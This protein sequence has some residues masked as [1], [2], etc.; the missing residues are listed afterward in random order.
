MITSPRH[1]PTLW[2]VLLG[3]LLMLGTTNAADPAPVDLS[4][5][6]DAIR[7]RHQV[8]G[9]AAA[10]IHDGK[11]LAIGAC[12]QR[13]QGSP[14]AITLEDRFH[15]G[16]CTKSMTATLAALLIREGK[17]DLQWKT[18]IGEVFVD[19]LT[20]I[21]PS[22]HPVTLEQLLQHLGGC[23]HDV[24]PPIWNQ[25]RDPKQTT[26]QHR[27]NLVH[28]IL[29]H[30]PAQEPGALPHTY[31][32]A[33]YVIAGAMLEQRTG[34]SW[35]Q[36]ITDYLFTPLGLSSF[37]FGTPANPDQQT[38]DQ[39]W[40]HV[41]RDGNPHP[42]PPGPT[43]DN[44][45][46]IG[47]AGTVHGSIRDLA[48]YTNLHTQG[49]RTG[50]HIGTI[51]LTPDDFTR[52]H[53]PP[54]QSTYASGWLRL[55]RPWAGRYALHHNGTNTMNY[56]VMW[57]SPDHHFSMVATCNLGGPPGAKACDDAM[58]LLLKRYKHLSAAPP[59][60]SGNPHK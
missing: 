41:P 9:L 1:L 26:A 27:T 20:E 12:G 45:A 11:I 23:P 16:S 2:P 38:I 10:L 49:A 24:P 14:E 22:Y 56:A 57:L 59:I 32:N 34:R 3:S 6:L 21:H 52:L 58:A 55:K 5:Q 4:P 37:G 19:R 39:P 43:G 42:I 51:T 28:G 50:A 7:K 25:L 33:G 60:E 36:L 18:S 8:P 30:K 35:E 54:A 29:A 40:G 48:R 46:A 17:N 47:P 15:F 31:S 44:P 53:T 13:K